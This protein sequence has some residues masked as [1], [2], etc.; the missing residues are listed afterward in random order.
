MNR[1]KTD[2]EFVLYVR[3]FTLTPGPRLED[4]GNFSGEEFRKRYLLPRYL[5]AV[6]NGGYLL[7]ILEGTKGY[8]SSFLEEAFG[9][10]VREG[11]KRKDLKDHLRIRTEDR[12]WYKPEIYSYIAE[13]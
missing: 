3:E 2:Q 12:P 5:E 1:D 8:A 9:G 11:L 6:K 4:D 13:A 7:V 10:L